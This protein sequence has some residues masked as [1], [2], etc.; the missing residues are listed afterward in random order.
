MMSS[1][2]NSV[3]GMGLDSEMQKRTK[4][5]KEECFSW[6]CEYLYIA[7]WYSSPLMGYKQKQFSQMVGYSWCSLNKNIFWV[8]WVFS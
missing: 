4:E 5:N 1:Q 2:L 6:T 8:F 3:V 7:G